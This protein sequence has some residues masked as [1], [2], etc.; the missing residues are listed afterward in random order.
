MAEASSSK[1]GGYASASAQARGGWRRAAPNRN[2]IFSGTQRATRSTSQP[3]FPSTVPAEADDQDDMMEVERA[4]TPQPRTQAAFAQGSPGRVHFAARPAPASPAHSPSA[5]SSSRLKPALSRSSQVYAEAQEIDELLQPH[6]PS[7][8][9]HRPPRRSSAIAVPT[10][11]QRYQTLTV[12]A[13]SVLGFYSA[14]E[15]E[16]TSRGTL[17][18]ASLTTEV[19]RNWQ[20]FESF[21]THQLM[22][23]ADYRQGFID[24]E[25]VI[26][27]LPGRKVPRGLE[28]ALHIAN[29]AVFLHYLWNLP[30]SRTQA[31]PS[32]I[33]SFRSLS[34]LQDGWRCFL[35]FILTKEHP[36]SDEVLG[37]YLEV[38]TQVYCQSYSE[39]R[40]G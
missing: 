9:P 23:L 5:S 18:T 17:N 14:I 7:P 36:L 27:S 35:Q 4:T 19:E 13:H 26:R 33:W 24:V 8:A 39:S 30:T 21:K 32:R 1:R 40:Q 3:A 10:L 15:A 28:E 20:P 11:T 6:S 34:Q 38:S 25:D 22:E 16:W 29:C 12:S 31:G 2:N 37:A